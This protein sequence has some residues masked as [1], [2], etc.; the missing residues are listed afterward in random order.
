MES[1]GNLKRRL[2]RVENTV[3][4]KH[5]LWVEVSAGESRSHALERA[6]KE[7]GVTPE[8]V[9]A[10]VFVPDLETVD[11][12]G[13]SGIETLAGYRSYEDILRELYGSN[14]DLVKNNG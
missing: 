11:Y 4:P 5:Y 12:G 7:A 8:Q 6:C 14:S 1:L 9:G 13:H 2:E 3:S 10:A